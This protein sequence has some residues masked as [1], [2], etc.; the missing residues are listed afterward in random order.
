M[1]WR[2]QPDQHI[3]DDLYIVEGFMNVQSVAVPVA[4]LGRY[5][6]NP[7]V[8]SIPINETKHIPSGFCFTYFLVSAAWG[9]DLVLYVW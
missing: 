3:L 1:R 5:G 6:L 8:T 9:F 7:N 2:R 4:F